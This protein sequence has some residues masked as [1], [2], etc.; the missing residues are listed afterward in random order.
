MSDTDRQLSRID[1]M[2]RSR[3]AFAWDSCDAG[4]VVTTYTVINGHKPA[5][6][7]GGTS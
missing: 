5:D 4:H 3:A 2:L 6:G 1:S 7:P